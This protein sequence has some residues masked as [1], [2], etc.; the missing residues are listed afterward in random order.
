MMTLRKFA[1]QQ[2]GTIVPKNDWRTRARREGVSF[3]E[4]LAT[5]KASTS[6][7]MLTELARASNAYKGFGGAPLTGYQKQII[8]NMA[9][10][11]LQSLGVQGIEEPIKLSPT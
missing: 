4:Y 2:V 6:I 7:K 8:S 3:E 9:K 10:Q 1:Q 5:I 11:R